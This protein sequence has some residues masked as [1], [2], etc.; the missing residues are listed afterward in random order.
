MKRWLTVLDRAQSLVPMVFLSSL[1]AF[2]WW[3]V[4]STPME[5]GARAPAKASSSPCRSV[6]PSRSP[7]IFTITAAGATRS[8][9]P[10]GSPVIARICCSNCDTRQASIV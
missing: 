2:T 10:R 3:L 7:K 9:L 6:G 1:A 4:Q 8:V 5:E